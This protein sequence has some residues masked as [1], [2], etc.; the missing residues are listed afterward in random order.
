ML[1]AGEEKTNSGKLILSI[2]RYNFI[3]SKDS[4]REMFTVEVMGMGTVHS[5]QVYFKS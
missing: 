4:C 1:V 3:E 5:M 2:K